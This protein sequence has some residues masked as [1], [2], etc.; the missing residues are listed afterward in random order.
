MK[1]KIKPDSDF[2]EILYVKIDDEHF[3]SYIADEKADELVDEWYGTIAVAT[4]RL[5]E[6]RIGKA[7]IEYTKIED[8]Q[9]DH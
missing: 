3:D 8:E 5:V 1:R 4:Y 7:T 9:N 6:V 2:P